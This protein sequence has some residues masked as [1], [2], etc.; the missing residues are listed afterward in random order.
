MVVSAS[1]PTHEKK[2]PADARCFTA[3]LE[4]KHT[5]LLTLL[6]YMYIPQKCRMHDVAITNYRYQTMKFPGHLF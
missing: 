4:L 1:A 5:L 2:R 3:E 6:L